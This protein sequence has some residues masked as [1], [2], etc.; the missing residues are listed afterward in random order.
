MKLLAL[1]SKL[2]VVVAVALP[3]A[4]ALPAG[5]GGA[6][7]PPGTAARADAAASSFE[8]WVMDQADSTA[9]GGG[10]L[11]V[12]PGDPL[13][14]GAAGAEP[15]VVDLGGAARDLCLAETGTTPQR[16]HMLMVNRSETH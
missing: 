4:L 1:S 13:T 12:Y 9:D 8:V 6:A 10:T 3:L 11:Y 2:L 15:E 14:A 16:P 5:A 7:S